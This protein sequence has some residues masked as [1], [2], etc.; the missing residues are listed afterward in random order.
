MAARNGLDSKQSLCS[1]WL[2]QVSLDISKPQRTPRAPTKSKGIPEC[3]GH[4][5]RGPALPAASA[6]PIIKAEGADHDGR[7]PVEEGPDRRE[8]DR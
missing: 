6:M 4:S 3:I 5:L 8:S 7:G 1:P 2:I